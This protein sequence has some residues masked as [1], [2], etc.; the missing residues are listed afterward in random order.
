MAIALIPARGGSKRIPNKN[1]KLFNGKPIIAYSIAAA[2][3]SGCFE[4]IIV[5]TDDS[6]IARVAVSCGAEVP[7]VRPA[8]ISDDYATT[9]DVIKHALHWLDAC[10]EMP[11]HLCTLYATAPFL[12]AEAISKALLLLRQDAAK[13]YCFGVAEYPSPIQRAFKI[14]PTGN[15]EMF[16]PEY[17]LTRSQDLE[18]AYFGAGQFYWGRSQA[19]LKDVPL[20]SE[21]SIPYVLPNHKVQDIDTLDD[22]IRAEVMYSALTPGGSGVIHSSTDKR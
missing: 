19:F 9:L 12:E 7:F 13:Q 16:H 1:I 15:I 6:D 11:E 8:D 21:A 4:R 5:S 17:F 14:T 22:W 10:G 18:K 2:R 20:Y 3:E